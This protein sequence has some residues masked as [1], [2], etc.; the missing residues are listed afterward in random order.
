MGDNEVDHWDCLHNL[1]FAAELDHA[2]EA[3]SGIQAHA[4][5]HY[6]ERV[7]IEREAG[8][9]EAGD[10]QRKADYERIA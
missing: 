3:R 2:N 8:D 1:H 5:L 9:G 4:S 7:L 6:L 10:H